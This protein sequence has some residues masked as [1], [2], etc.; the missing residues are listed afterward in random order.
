MIVGHGIDLMSTARITAAIQRFGDTFINR[1]YTQYERETVAARSKNRSGSRWT[2][3]AHQTF[4]AFWAVKE[5]V[6]KALGTGNRMGVHFR[7][8]EIRHHSTGKPY[9]VLYGGSRERARSLGV[10]HIH[11]SMTHLDDL[12]AASVIFESNQVPGGDTPGA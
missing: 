7:D 10:D 4:T 5:A 6:M 2:Q 3:R 11:V 8:I 1:V 9:V 12:S